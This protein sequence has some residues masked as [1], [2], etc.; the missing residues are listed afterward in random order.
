MAVDLVELRS[1]LDAATVLLFFRSVIRLKP[2]TDAPLVQYPRIG[3]AARKAA[4]NKPGGDD[5]YGFR[6]AAGVAE[7]GRSIAD[8]FV[9]DGIKTESTARIIGARVQ[10]HI[11]LQPM[12]FQG[13]HPLIGAN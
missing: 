1:P 6:E 13:P 9:G 7:R 3:S 10:I 2:E 8:G 4:G 12:P 11:Q 5:R